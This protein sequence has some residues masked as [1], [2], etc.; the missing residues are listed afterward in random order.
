V[1]KLAAFLLRLP[2][3]AVEKILRFIY[4]AEAPVVGVSMAGYH[5]SVGGVA[6]YKGDFERNIDNQ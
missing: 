1:S 6:N 4:L 2:W 3:I 5:P